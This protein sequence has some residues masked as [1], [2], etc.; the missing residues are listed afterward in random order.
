MAP[1]GRPDPGGPPL[2]GS[3][4][5][6]PSREST[7]RA[8]E[9]PEGPSSPPGDPLAES[10]ERVVA[11]VMRKRALLGTV[12]QHATVVHVAGEVLTV[13]LGGSPFHRELLANQANRDL[14]N[15]AVQQHVPGAKRINVD[16]DGPIQSDAKSHPAVQA[17]VEAF[18]GDIVAVRPRVPGEG[19][20]R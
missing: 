3:A 12:L 6:S 5:V 15:Q 8:T 17:A 18:Q 4:G 10:W 2:S 9:T 19:D 11:E 13:S 16:V 7:V 1:V 20:S 14:I